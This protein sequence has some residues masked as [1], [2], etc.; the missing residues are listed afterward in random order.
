MPS[1]YVRGGSSDCLSLVSMLGIEHGYKTPVNP[2][3][4]RE[5][6]YGHVCSG[7]IHELYRYSPCSAM[8]CH[9][10]HH[11]IPAQVKALEALVP[12]VAALAANVPG[13]QTIARCW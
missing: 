2:N 9:A 6:V 3:L 5:P 8:G 7:H 13:T 12:I 1:R 4:E 11:L 10:W